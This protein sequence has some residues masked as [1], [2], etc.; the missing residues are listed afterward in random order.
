MVPAEVYDRIEFICRALKN[1]PTMLSED[2]K[3][4]LYDELE[5]LCKIILSDR[6]KQKMKQ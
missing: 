6:T 2:T 4:Q 3:N 5:L 1:S